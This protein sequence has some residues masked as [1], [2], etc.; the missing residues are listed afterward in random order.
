[1]ANTTKITKAMVLSAI[2]AMVEDEN[3]VIELE[4]GIKV[5]GKDV[6]DYCDNALAQ[7]EHKASQAKERA[8]KT[9]AEGD[10]LRA[11]V[12]SHVTDEFQTGD[13]IAD[14]VTGFEDVTKSKIVARL[15]Q[16]VKNGDVVKES[17]KIDGRKVMCYRLA[18]AN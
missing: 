9:K 8:A 6:V 4:G 17:Q 10:E 1:M 5:T 3:D 16:L 12:L 18:S 14:A 11:E 15:S 2:M 7:L 13:E